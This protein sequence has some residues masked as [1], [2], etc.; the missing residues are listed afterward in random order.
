MATVF[1]GFPRFLQ[2]ARIKPCK[3]VAMKNNIDAARIK[4]C[5]T[6]AMK[7]NIDAARIKPCKTVAMN[8]GLGSLPITYLN[9]K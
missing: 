8:S 9:L 4:P 7:N 6:V 5:K 2:I 1:H 3:T